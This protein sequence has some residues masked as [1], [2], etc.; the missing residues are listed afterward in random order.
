MPDDN[1]FQSKHVV[2]K[3]NNKML[4]EKEQSVSISLQGLKQFALGLTIVNSAVLC[5]QSNEYVYDTNETYSVPSGQT[6][7][8]R[9]YLTNIIFPPLCCN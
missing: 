6:H 7:C 9:H 8:A 3:R 4:C 1:R 2:F 5:S